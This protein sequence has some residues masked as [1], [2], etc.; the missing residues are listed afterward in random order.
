ML[1]LKFLIYI[2]KVKINTDTEN[3]TGIKE[4]GYTINHKIMFKLMKF[5]NLKGKQ[6]K[7]F[8]TRVKLIK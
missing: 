4:K 6:Q 2:V 7:N 5:L 8:H 3:N 1:K